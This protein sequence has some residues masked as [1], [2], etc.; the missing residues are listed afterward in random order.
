V[1]GD[2]LGLKYLRVLMISLRILDRLRAPH[3]SEVHGRL[4]ELSFTN[5]ISSYQGTRRAH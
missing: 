1:F 2:Y 5:E 4:F 3:P